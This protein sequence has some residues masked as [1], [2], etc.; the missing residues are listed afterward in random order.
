MRDQN[1]DSGVNLRTGVNLHTAL[2]NSTCTVIVDF[3]LSN[4][5]I[6][7]TKQFEQEDECTGF[8]LCMV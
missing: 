8:A 6:W 4:V 5:F 3:S 2:V 1:K 7:K